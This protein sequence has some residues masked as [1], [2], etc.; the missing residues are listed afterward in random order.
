[1]RPLRIV[2]L[3]AAAGLA[4]FVPFVAARD[5]DSPSPPTPSAVS[6]WEG[7]VGSAR[8][9]VAV[10]QR[11]LVVLTAPSLAQR[12]GAAG[13]FAGDAAERRWTASALAAQQEFLSELATKGIRIQPEYRFTRVLNGFSAAVDPKAA[14]LLERS[15]QVR[16]VYPVRVSYPASVSSSPAA[17]PPG[18]A[19]TLGDV[20]GTGVTIALLDTGVDPATRDQ[21][22]SG[23]RP[24][25]DGTKC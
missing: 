5:Q 1:M 9:Q 25:L 16:G 3:A 14:A 20:R 12:V 10:G 24:V 2:G 6:G 17:G 21:E 11:V 19:V 8:P 13:G 7:L 18:S 22:N 15:P 23:D 4:A